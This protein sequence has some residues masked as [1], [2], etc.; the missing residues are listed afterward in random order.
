MSRRTR[1]LISN[2]S[3]APHYLQG[4]LWHLRLLISVPA[5][6]TDSPTPQGIARDRIRKA[7]GIQTSQDPAFD[8]QWGGSYYRFW[9]KSNKICLMCYS[10]NGQ[11]VLSKS[12]QRHFVHDRCPSHLVLS[13]MF[14][15]RK[16]P[17]VQTAHNIYL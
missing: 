8:S 9:G 10:I 2:Y 16:W 5:D 12:L 17:L 14:M 13:K 4:N 6:I 15:L 11:L 1:K 3:V 7:T